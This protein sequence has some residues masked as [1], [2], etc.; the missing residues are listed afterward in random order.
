MS[1]DCEFE[2]GG[3]EGPVCAWSPGICKSWCRTNS[4]QWAPTALDIMDEVNSGSFL[5]LGFHF[6]MLSKP[7]LR[8]V[9]H[10]CTADDHVADMHAET[11]DSLAI[12][13]VFGLG[14]VM[15]KQRSDLSSISCSIAVSG[16]FKASTDR[17][18][19]PPPAVAGAWEKWDHVASASGWE[20]RSLVVGMAKPSNYFI[21]K[22]ATPD[23]QISTDSCIAQSRQQATEAIAKTMGDDMDS[24]RMCNSKLFYKFRCDTAPW[25]YAKRKAF[26]TLVNLLYNNTSD[27]RMHKDIWSSHV[28]KWG[29]AAMGP[30]TSC[31]WGNIHVSLR[32]PPP[33]SGSDIVWGSC[34]NSGIIIDLDPRKELS[35]IGIDVVTS[36]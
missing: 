7:F 31:D 35:P 18:E 13:G 2:M 10:G 17:L 5:G 28:V 11:M 29:F 33:N 22:T 12:D 4:V 1:V 23:Q 19:A 8:S 30:R 21:A 32:R 26:A 20:V 36:W 16:L 34:I 15:G 14:N 27:G 9:V 25:P 24:M 3:P 6:D